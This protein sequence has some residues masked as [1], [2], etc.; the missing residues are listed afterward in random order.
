METP[1]NA[2]PG[3]ANVPRP[4]TPVGHTDRHRQ[5]GPTR[6][7]W[8][9]ST[10]TVWSF[11]GDYVHADPVPAVAKYLHVTWVPQ[12][13]PLSGD[14]DTVLAGRCESY[15][16][17]VA[18]ALAR[19]MSSKDARNPMVEEQWLEALSRLKGA[20]RRQRQRPRV[21]GGEGRL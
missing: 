3:E 2:V 21:V 14:S 17:M 4:W 13:A 10:G 16:N 15:G 12:L 19:R 7:P 20:T 18:V 8:S 5:R 6:L 1:N 11:Q 9:R